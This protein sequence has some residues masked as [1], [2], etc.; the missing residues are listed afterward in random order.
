MV[1][2]DPGS[3]AP[4]DNYDITISDADGADIMG[5]ETQNRDTATSEQAVPK[6]G[7]AYGARPVHGTITVSFT[8]QANAD[9]D[10]EIII[11]YVK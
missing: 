3:E 6:I 8:E 4:A 1:V 7:N 10:G 5:G 2:T 9:C 11:Y